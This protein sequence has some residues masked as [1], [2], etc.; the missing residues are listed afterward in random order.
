MQERTEI[1]Q[2]QDSYPCLAQHP[3]FC[4]VTIHSV[5][6]SVVLYKRAHYILI[7]GITQHN[8]VKRAEAISEMPLSQG[9]WND[10]D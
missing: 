4:C 5:S 9:R 10:S 3:S 1:I 2:K 8:S 6:V 7:T